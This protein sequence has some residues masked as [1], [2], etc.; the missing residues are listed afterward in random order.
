MVEP[1]AEF[2]VLQ[3]V[4]RYTQPR[5]RPGQAGQAGH[6]VEGLLG[7]HLPQVR[8]SGLI[9][10][11]V[12]HVGDALTTR[13]DQMEGGSGRRRAVRDVVQRPGHEIDR[14]H[15]GFAEFGCQQGQD[16]GQLRGHAQQP[17]EVV[18]PATR[19]TSPVRECPSTIDGR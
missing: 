18:R 19:S 1:A 9:G 10:E 5:E 3:H 13:V 2:A 15:I 6:R 8:H 12:E 11:Q 17:E 16:P 14:H 7:H 4:P